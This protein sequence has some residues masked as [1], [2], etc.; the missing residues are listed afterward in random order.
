MRLRVRAADNTIQ[1]FPEGTSPESVRMGMLAYDNKDDWG[2]LANEIRAAL[3]QSTEAN[4]QPT[5]VEGVTVVAARRKPS[6][7]HPNV[8][9]SLIPVWGAGREAIADFQEGDYFGAGINAALAG[10]DLFLGTS[11]AKGLAKGGL[12]MMKGGVGRPAS[13]ATWR[14]IRS[15]MAAK[16]LIAKGQHGHHWLIPQ[17]E[18]GKNWPNW[19]KNHPLNIK[20]MPTVAVPNKNGRTIDYLSEMHGRLDAR[21][22]KKPRFNPAQR[23]WY[24]TPN[25]V[26]P[27]TVEVVGHPADGANRIRKR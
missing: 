12:F 1:T 26:K 21:Y 9:E 11:V 6:I 18:W 22:G 19:I 13:S 3:G 17:N 2:Q 15:E 4:D 8:V 7:G 25:W 24:G 16:G 14:K 10:S 27:A 20:P 5:D 23:Y